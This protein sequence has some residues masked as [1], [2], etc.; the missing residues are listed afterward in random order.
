MCCMLYANKVL[1]VV[2]M[3]D[4]YTAIHNMHYNIKYAN[5]ILK[6]DYFYLHCIQFNTSVMEAI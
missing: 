6:R 2:Y 5:K 1:Y 4:T 3:I